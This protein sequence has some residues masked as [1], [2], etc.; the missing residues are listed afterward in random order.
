MNKSDE[1]ADEPDGENPASVHSMISASMIASLL[2]HSVVH[3]DHQ[4]YFA[5]PPEKRQKGPM[6]ARLVALA[7]GAV[8][9]SVLEAIET[10]SATSTSWHHALKVIGGAA[11]A[12][13]SEILALRRQTSPPVTKADNPCIGGIA[14]KRVGCPCKADGRVREDR[15]VN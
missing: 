2:V 1:E 15:F 5:T 4:K 6:H 14:D 12:A 8:H 3:R 9:G 10:P 7:P 11:N 13:S